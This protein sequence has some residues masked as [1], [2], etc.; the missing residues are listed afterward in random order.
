MSTFNNLSSAVW[1]VPYLIA[2]GAVILFVVAY[3]SHT[4][5]GDENI[6]E[7]TAEDLLRRE[8]KIQ[9]EFSGVK[10]D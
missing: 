9:V 8:Y 2:A 6:I 7:E 3:I 5:L 10:N 4:L 1:M